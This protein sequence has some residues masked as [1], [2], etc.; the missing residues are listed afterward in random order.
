MYTITEPHN[1]HRKYINT[2]VN[3][4]KNGNF[5]PTGQKLNYAM[6]VLFPKST[7]ARNEVVRYLLWF[8]EMVASQLI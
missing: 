3:G 2:N 8:C 1:L 4:K 6:S 5:K 7:L